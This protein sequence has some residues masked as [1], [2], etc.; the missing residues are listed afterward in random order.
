MAT[1]EK[2]RKKSALLFTIIIVALL[3]FILGDFLT[4]GRSFFGH[5][6]T[7][8]KVAGHKVDY[9]QVSER[10]EQ[11]SQQAQAQGQN[12]DGETLR[13]MA[14]QQL[15]AQKLLDEEIAELGIAVTDAEI[16]AGL[17]GAMPH[18]AAQQF[19]YQMSQSLGLPGMSGQAVFDAVSN[20]A[21]YGITDQ[22]T[23]SQLRALWAAQEQQLEEALKQEKLTRLL[24]GLYTANKID[25]DEL[26]TDR[27]TTAHISYAAKD[28]TSV[29][30]SEVEVTDA[31]LKKEWQDHKENYRLNEDSRSVSY[32]I[33]PIEPSA[34]DIRNA[35]IAVNQAIATLAADTTGVSSLQDN[36]AF[37]INRISTPRR[38]VQNPLLVSFLDTARVGQ[39][40]E[41]MHNNTG[42][43][44]AK[45]ISRTQQTDSVRMSFALFENAEGRDSIVA[46]INNGDISIS[47]YIAANQGVGQDSIWDTM[48]GNGAP[49]ELNSII[50]NAPFGK[51][52]AYSDSVMAADGSY[53]Q[54]YMAIKVIDRKPAV[55]VYDVAIIEYPVDPSSE[56]IN[57]LT[58]DFRKYLAENTTAQAFADNAAE[59]GYNVQSGLVSASLPQLGINAYG[60]GIDDSR[61]LIKW[62]MENK[63]GTVSPIYQ[64]K[65]QSYLAAIAVNDLFEDYIPYNTPEVKEALT[66]KVLADKK[67]EKLIGEYAGK[68]SDIQ[69]YAKLMGT[70]V[71]QTDVN[72][73]SPMFGSLGFNESDLQGAA[74]AA[75]KGDLVGPVKG[76][77]RVVV[78]FVDGVD[79]E[80]RPNV[81]N[82][83]AMEFNR[84]YGFGALFNN[85]NLFN[86]L[87]GT[88]EVTNYSLDF[89][90]P[91]L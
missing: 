46:R 73:A 64:D 76:N 16:T 54:R 60:R 80:G 28:F 56:T 19:I 85:N 30:D 5:G 75:K 66:T 12:I 52:V 53:Q 44:L 26:Y 90:N 42:Y 34:Q 82:E 38:G 18:P 32:I 74:A 61:A 20:P 6:T 22:Q 29:P 69:G 84:T 89:E 49:A 14:I 17:T 86:V 15:L 37:T 63:K 87:R 47:D 83:N 25:A 11:L 7:M 41:L 10:V 62:A 8:A 27:N 13:Q 91:G 24:S 77:T 36:T 33:V 79:T 67:A 2:I 21:K 40:A 78:F 50:A 9:Q 35:E 31:D 51:T 81:F 68:A 55:P 72:F 59:A 43:S 71:A 65:R 4:S 70:E 23:V 48:V 39:V 57:A 58:S 1:L 3:A 88:S 45:L